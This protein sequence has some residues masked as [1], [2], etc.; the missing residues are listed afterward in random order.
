MDDHIRVLVA[1]DHPAVRAGVRV[2]LELAENIEVVGEAGTSERAVQLAGELTPD[3][4]TMDLRIPEV[5]GIEATRAL[6]QA[7]P[8]VAVLILTMVQ[9]DDAVFAAL[10]AGARGYLLKGAGQD[11]LT[12]A[13]T[14]VASGEFIA[15]P[16]VAQQISRFLAGSGP[17]SS[18]SIAFP[19]L[20]AR[21]REV[22]N[23]MAEGLNNASIARRLVLSPKTVRNHI[24]AIFSKL[25]ITERAT[26]IVRARE[27]G[28]GRQPEAPAR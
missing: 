22:L 1:D 25:Q 23:L 6:V 8:G 28:L 4:I 10:R 19:L 17:D 3:V 27:V 24:S 21:E 20:T 2:L 15:S 9:D 5:G 14:A 13:V 26:A 7:T 11:E 16:A 18:A 12:R